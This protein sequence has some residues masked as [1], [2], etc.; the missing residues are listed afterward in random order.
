MTQIFRHLLSNAIK[1]RGKENPVITIDC[2]NKNGYYLFSVRDNGIGIP[3]KYQHIIFKP[4]KRLHAPDEIEG[5]GLGLAICEK[6]V[7]AHGG[8]IWVESKPGEGS[9]FFFII[10]NKD[11]R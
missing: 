10:P 5:S 6:A 2:V 4:L 7:L 3:E 9:V 11:G 8:R 1:Y